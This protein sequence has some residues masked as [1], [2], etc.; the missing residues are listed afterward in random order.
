[1]AVA[2]SAADF[3]EAHM[4]EDHSADA[5]IDAQ[6]MEPAREKIYD[7]ETGEELVRVNQKAK[8]YLRT[9]GKGKKQ[10]ID[11]A[12]A[13][14]GDET[15]V[16]DA[17]RTG[18]TTNEDRPEVLESVNGDAEQSGNEGANDEG[19]DNPTYEN[20]SIQH[21]P[22]PTTPAYSAEDL[23]AVYAIT[24]ANEIALPNGEGTMVAESDEQ[25]SHVREWE[26]QAQSGVKQ[27]EAA[28]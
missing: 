16:F 10:K 19:A 2:G 14:E 28:E 9:K 20:V 8:S 23:D 11:V 27:L 13:P 7:A 26:R 15:G 4:I 24:E 22:E 18:T 12:G 3:D 17:S 21:T 6:P 5:P 1:M 25:D